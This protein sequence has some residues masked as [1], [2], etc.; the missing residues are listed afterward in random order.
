M[1][2]RPLDWVLCLSSSCLTF[3]QHPLVA[4]SIAAMQRSHTCTTVVVFLYVRTTHH[5]LAQPGGPVSRHVGSM[6][7]IRPSPGCPLLQG[8][9]PLAAQRGRLRALC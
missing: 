3:S 5:T 9:F 2:R 7:S 4:L 8:H 1:S 6:Q